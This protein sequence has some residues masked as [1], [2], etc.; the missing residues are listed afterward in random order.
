[1][2][3]RSILATASAVALVLAPAV[4]QVS[5][6]DAAQYPPR[7]CSAF[8]RHNP[9][10]QGGADAIEGEGYDPGS[11]IVVDRG[12]QVVARVK[13][14]AD[15]TFA[16]GTTFPDSRGVDVGVEGTDARA[17]NAG[18]KKPCKVKTHVD[19]AAND[20]ATS[21]PANSVSYASPLPEVGSV[22][23]LAGVSLLGLGVFIGAASAFR[24][25]FVL[26]GR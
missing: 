15:G 9:V 5:T 23:Q 14:A 22:G 26:R 16:I 19:V 11:A 4:L 18:R 2:L 6:A 10:K 13:A 17:D 24:R 1:M 8:H 20:Q 3:N 12:G 7:G 25:R 21:V